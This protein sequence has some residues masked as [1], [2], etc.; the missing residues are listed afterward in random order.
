MS[1]AAAHATIRPSRRGALCSFVGLYSALDNADTVWLLDALDGDMDAVEI[2]STLRA[3]G[4]NI[5]STTV[6][7]HRRQECTCEPR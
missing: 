4:H 1:L 7:R 2:S 3:A 6:R 5:S